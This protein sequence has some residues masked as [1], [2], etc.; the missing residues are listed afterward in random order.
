MSVYGGISIYWVY[1]TGY[2]YIGIQHT[3]RAQGGT[4]IYVGIRW[5][6]NWVYGIQYVRREAPGQFFPNCGM[7]QPPNLRLLH[8]T[9]VLVS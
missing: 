1:D 2:I 6:I 5:Y 9:D 4:S 3:I 8:Y 7:N